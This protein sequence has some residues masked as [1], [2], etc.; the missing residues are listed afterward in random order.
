MGFTVFQFYKNSDNDDMNLL[1]FI[2]CSLYPCLAL[3]SDCLETVPA[4]STFDFARAILNL[5]DGIVLKQRLMADACVEFQSNPKDKV[6]LNELLADARSS[7]NLNKA[8]SGAL[9]AVAQINS[10]AGLGDSP[11]EK[12]Y[13]S[14]LAEIAGVQ[15]VNDRMRRVYILAQKYQ[16][17]WDLDSHKE[18]S[19]IFG[20]KTPGEVIKDANSTGTGGICRDF[21][22]LLVWSLNQVRQ[23]PQNHY[24]DYVATATA[25]PGHAIVTVSMLEPI[26]HS[27]KSRFTLDPTNQKE[28]TPSPIWDLHSKQDKMD[29]YLNQCMEIRRCLRNATGASPAPAG[30]AK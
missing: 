17:K 3:A 2:F 1:V 19:G 7:S 10:S 22:T 18:G 4:S 29:D 6:H 20:G 24:P 25:I 8:A 12:Q 23:S 28:F 27:V 26:Q 9:S 11:I 15:N 5:S 16:G 13:K 30:A 21:S 14:E